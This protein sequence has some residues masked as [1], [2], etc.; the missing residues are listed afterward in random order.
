MGFSPLPRS[1]LYS[2]YPVAANIVGI[3]RKNENSKAEARDIPA[4]WPPAIVDI[5][6]DVPGNTPEKIWQKP[7]HTDWPR[8]MFSIFQVWMRPP[9]ADGPAAS[10]LAFMASTIHM[11]T[12]PI[13][14]DQPIIVRLS[15][16]LPITL[17]SRNEGIAVTTKATVTSP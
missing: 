4:I 9:P 11:M 6:R 14:N 13:S 1:D 2:V 10:D 5:E 12:P 8:L 15:R 16:C 3:D 17:V 7:I